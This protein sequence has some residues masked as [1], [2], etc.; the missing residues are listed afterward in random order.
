MR[1]ST[2]RLKA[3]LGGGERGLR[4]PNALW[5]EEPGATMLAALAGETTCE[6]GAFMM[7]NAAALI[8][9]HGSSQC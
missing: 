6:H 1:V 8:I 2:A 3:F 4:A 9:A 7:T 5:A